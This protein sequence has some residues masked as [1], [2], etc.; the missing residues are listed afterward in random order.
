MY[1]IIYY[2]W[3]QIYLICVCQIFIEYFMFTMGKSM[4]RGN[5]MDATSFIIIIIIEDMN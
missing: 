3:N 2:P 1:L 4:A 5:I